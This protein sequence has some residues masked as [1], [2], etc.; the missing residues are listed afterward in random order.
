VA[1]AHFFIE[2][3]IDKLVIQ[4]FQQLPELTVVERTAFD[5]IQSL[6]LNL[7]H[8]LNSE[9]LNTNFADE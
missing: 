5:V 2:W 1:R 9:F 3:N 6:V 8:T 7:A 4:I